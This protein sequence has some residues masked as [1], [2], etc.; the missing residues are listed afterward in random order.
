MTY[1]IYKATCVITGKAYIGFTSDYVR[2][3]AEHLKADKDFHFH[4]AIRKHGALNFHWE[5]LWKGEDGTYGLKILEPKLIEEHQTFGK[6]GYNKTKGGQGTIGGTWTHSKETKERMRESRLAWI[7]KN[8]GVLQRI[9]IQTH[10]GRKRSPETRKKIS[11]SRKGM[12]LS[13]LHKN[14]IS[15]SI[16]GSKNPRAKCFKVTFPDGTSQIVRDRV[17]FCRQQNLNYGTARWAC[18]ANKKDGRNRTVQKF[19]F[20]EIN[21]LQ[22]I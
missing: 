17:E 2:R 14:N 1:T 20:E 7:R 18:L 13:T 12:K 16:T 3:K 9:L 8:P 21:N 4:R 5:I 22:A 11:D 6:K 10:L 19:L 15:K